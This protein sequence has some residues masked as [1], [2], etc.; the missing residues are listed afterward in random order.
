MNDQKRTFLAIALSA[1]VIFA[2]QYYFTST[3]PASSESAS[4]QTVSKD[5]DTTMIPVKDD[6]SKSPLPAEEAVAGA[7]LVVSDFVVA[8]DR[9]NF[10]FASDFSILRV[11]GREDPKQTFSEIVVSK[12]PFLRISVIEGDKV[13][14]LNLTIL[15]KD[16]SSYLLTDSSLGVKVSLNF[17][18][19]DKLQYVIDSARPYQYQIEMNAKETAENPTQQFSTYLYNGA[20][21]ERIV[22][23]KDDVESEEP[24]RWVGIDYNYQLLSM[25]FVDK[26]S[27]KVNIAKEG[28]AIIRLLEAKNN[29]SGFFV[30]KRKDYD[31]LKALG[32]QL[33]LAVDFGIFGIVAVPILKGL[34]FFYKI[35]PN[36]GV[37]II[38]MTILIKI[39]TFPLQYKSYQSMKKM[40]QIQPELNKLKEKYKDD[41]QAIQRETMALFKRAGANPMGGC[42]PIF[43]N[44]KYCSLVCE[45]GVKVFKYISSER[46]TA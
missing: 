29:L 22:I 5:I 28:P 1:L 8:G 34:K 11:D 37:A 18:K 7:S 32:G 2:W 9:V 4:K 24:I 23:G 41:A 20:S 10:L 31:D 17:D 33:H 15:S 42:L 39:I 25:V 36:F 16:N 12:N 6:S 26:I 44:G 46:S 3:T 43:D 40:Q 35:F 45:I 21:V 38:L 13:R 27:A 14:P 19:K 30:Y